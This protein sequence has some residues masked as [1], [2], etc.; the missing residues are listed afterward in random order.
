MKRTAVAEASHG[1]MLIS[2]PASCLCILDPRISIIRRLREAAGE[3][4]IL[5]EGRSDQAALAA[6]GIPSKPL[7]HPLYAI[8]ESI[9]TK[10][11]IILT[12]RDAHGERLYRQLK[13]ACIHQG[14]RVDDRLREAFFSIFHVSHVEEVRLPE[15]LTGLLATGDWL[16][17]ATRIPL[18]E[19]DLSYH[20]KE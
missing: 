1:I 4:V 18:A 14:I 6:L 15:H 9:R 11:V 3:A 19:E 5:V 17:T 12:D 10:N 2:L 13:H 8:V 20:E 7:H 16:D